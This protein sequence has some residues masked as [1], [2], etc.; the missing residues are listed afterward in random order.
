MIRMVYVRMANSKAEEF[1]AGDLSLSAGEPVVVESDKGLVLGKVLSPPQE[2]EKR[3]ILKSPRK[4]ARKAAPEDLEQFE[5]NKQL[6]KDAFQFCMEKVKEKN[7][8][9]KLV[10]TEVLLDRSKV[11]FYFTAEK[12]VDFRELVKDLAAQFR[13]RI[14]MRQIGVRDEAKMICGVGGCGR[15]LCCAKF[16]NRFELVSVKM[17]KEQ[18]IALN[19][20]KISG[21]CGRLM[22]CLAYEYP[23]YMELKK[24]LPKVGKH[25]VTRSGKGKVI[26][27]N[28]LNQTVTVQLEEGGEV[29]I[30]ASEI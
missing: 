14:E 2:K 18:N 11:L 22:C 5:K 27:Q 1:D 3:F 13:M 30:H 12:R 26:R 8:Q 15:E 21:I 10:K 19:P 25:I 24:N 7:L 4:V 20:T 23:T 16:M 28:V 29:T 6:E 9:M 17:A